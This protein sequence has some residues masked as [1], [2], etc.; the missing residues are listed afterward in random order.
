MAYKPI[1]NNSEF[2]KNGGVAGVETP[3]EG[4]AEAVVRANNHSPL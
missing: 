4:V 1:K 2:E 3:A